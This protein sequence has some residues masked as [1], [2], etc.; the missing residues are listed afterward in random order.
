MRERA[1][2]QISKRNWTQLKPTFGAIESFEPNKLDFDGIQTFAPLADSTADSSSNDSYIIFHCQA[3]LVR[4]RVK[5]CFLQNTWHKWMK[6]VTLAKASSYLITNRASYR[7]LS[8]LVLAGCIW[9]GTRPQ[10]R[11]INSVSQTPWAAKPKSSTWVM[12]VS[13]LSRI[14]AMYLV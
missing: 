3:S 10:D 7:T 8:K 14:L 5:L 9:D 2:C 13:T 12:L 6:V 4:H 1:S 11:W